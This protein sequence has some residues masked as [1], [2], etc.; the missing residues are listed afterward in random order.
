MRCFVHLARGWPELVLFAGDT[1]GGREQK[2]K[3]GKDGP[4]HTHF[5]KNDVDA[6]L[7]MYTDARTDTRSCAA[8]AE[9]WARGRVPSPSGSERWAA[10]HVAGFTMVLLAAEGPRFARELPGGRYRLRGS[11]RGWSTWRGGT[12]RCSL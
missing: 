2:E 1:L 9:T 4:E 3:R 10:G 12:F 6:G 8:R 5:H 11:S 7:G